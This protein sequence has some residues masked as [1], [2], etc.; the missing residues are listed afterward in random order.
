M[1]PPY[2]RNGEL[3]Y[4]FVLG[5]IYKE[6]K[7]IKQDYILSFFSPGTFLGERYYTFLKCKFYRSLAFFT[8]LSSKVIM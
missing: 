6:K 2:L 8:I 5:F 4:I 1:Q 3:Q 7:I